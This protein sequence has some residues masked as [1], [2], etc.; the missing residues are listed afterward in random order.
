MTARAVLLEL[1]RGTGVVLLA[2]LAAVGSLMSVMAAVSADRQ[3]AWSGSGPGVVSWLNT[4]G[5]LLG[6]IAAAAGAWVG[7]RERR[8]GVQ[9]LLAAVPKARWR[10][11]LAGFGALGAAVAGGL[12][13]VAVLVAATVLPAFS[14]GGG[15]W[16]LSALLVL[17]GCVAC[18]AIGFGIGRLVPH[19]WTAPVVALGVYLLSGVPTYLDSGVAQLAPV[20]NLPAGDG[21]RLRL[22]VA[23][24]AVG[25]LVGLSAT[26]F[27]I[28]SARRRGWAGLPALMAI[29]VAVPLALLPVGWNGNSYSAA[30]TEPD[31]DA[32]ARVC[33][34]GTPTVCLNA[35]HAALLPAVTELARPILAELPPDSVAAE[36]GVEHPAERPTTAAGELAIPF[37]EGRA[38]WFSAELRDPERLRTELAQSFLR[39]WCTDQTGVV[40]RAYDLAITLVPAGR[41]AGEP[42]GDQLSARLRADPAARRAWLA[43]YLDAGRRCDLATYNALV[44]R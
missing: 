11:D 19:R 29:L 4:A 33:S 16:P 30:W 7:G 28:G 20:S 36:Q 39:P 25:W 8:L 18:L 43:S 3:T 41:G 22:A 31:P 26:A 27:L 24:L 2:A 44:G 15:R 23:A 40:D 1:R 14:Y 6:P 38:A 32:M 21:Q 9:E 35:V 37:L 10:R 12:A 13:L 17:L 42:G 34:T 5:L